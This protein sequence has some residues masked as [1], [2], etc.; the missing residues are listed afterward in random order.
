[1]A[2]STSTGSQ[3]ALARVRGPK[4]SPQPGLEPHAYKGRPPVRSHTARVVQSLGLAIV[5][6]KEA[7]GAVLPGDAD[8]IARYGVSRTVVREA[9]KTLAAKGLVQAK[10]RIG[11][12]VRE[13]AAWNLFDPDVLIWHAETGFDGDFLRSLGEVRLAM[14]PEAAALAAARRTPEDME[15][16]RRWA[17]RM[18][19]DGISQEDFV[20]ADLGFHLAVSQAAGNPFLVSLATLIEVALVAMLT[21][22]SPVESP[23]RLSGSVRSHAAIAD[24]IEAQDGTAAR[25]AMRT[26]ILEG[27]ENARAG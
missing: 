3:A 16:I 15:R 2:D 25:N 22:S 17:D 11:T 9:L 8:L 12:S 27:I 14:E 6:G 24:A 19:A 21:I 26:V 13:R 1:V 23:I 7:E 20:N 10:T 5:S 18:G 4:D